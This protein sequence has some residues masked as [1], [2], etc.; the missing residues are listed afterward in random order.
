MTLLLWIN[1]CTVSRTLTLANPKEAMN[2][3]V[4]ATFTSMVANVGAHIRINFPKWGQVT[5]LQSL[6]YIS[7]AIAEKMARDLNVSIYTGMEPVTRP[8]SAEGARK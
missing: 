3:E 1:T 5:T 2:K 8:G 6:G 7:E 4:L